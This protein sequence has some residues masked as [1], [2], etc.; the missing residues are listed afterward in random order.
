MALTIPIT[1]KKNE[2]SGVNDKVNE[3]IK[4]VTTAAKNT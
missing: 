3:H 2:T 1:N 4:P